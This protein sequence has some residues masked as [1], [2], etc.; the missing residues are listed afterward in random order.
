MSS[1]SAKA[2]T[3]DGASICDLLASGSLLATLLPL[4]L[5]WRE[6]LG[7]EEVS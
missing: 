1:T 6:E 3:L 7:D 4:L 2:A 5:E